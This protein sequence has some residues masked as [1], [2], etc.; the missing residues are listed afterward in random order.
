MFSQPRVRSALLSIFAALAL[1][2]ISAGTA[3]VSTSQGTTSSSVGA[4]RVAAAL[5]CNLL[6]PFNANNFPNSPNINNTWFPL[7]PGT[8]FVLDGRVNVGGQRLDHQVVLIVTDLT[9]VVHGVRTVVLWDRDFNTGVLVES[10]LTFHA[11]DNA[12]NIWNLG[13]YPAQYTAGNFTGAQDTWISGLA[14]A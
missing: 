10:E 5:P 9:K 3:Q 8:K 12:G 6:T 11:Q 1:L 14:N 13:E 2:L 7:V 4:S